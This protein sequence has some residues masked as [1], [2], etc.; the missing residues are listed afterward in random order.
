MQ[1]NLSTIVS[2][3]MQFAEFRNPL[4]VDPRRLHLFRN[5]QGSLCLLVEDY[6]CYLRVKVSLAFP[7]SYPKGYIGIADYKGR[8]IALIPHLEDL[9]PKSQ[10]LVLE[11]LK[12]RYFVPLVQKILSIREA[13][14]IQEWQVITDRGPRTF[15]VRNLL[16]NLFEASDN[17]YLV[18]DVQG[19][20]Y[21]LPFPEEMDPFSRR[22]VIGVL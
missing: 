2:V 5:P 6:C 9:D 10:Q 13:H 8:Q 16:D 17:R 14:G 21:L 1:E 18:I 3:E 22:Q 15:Y 19:N 4:E 7:Q 11:E 20:R 12:R